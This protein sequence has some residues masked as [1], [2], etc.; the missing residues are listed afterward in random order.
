MRLAAISDVHS[1]L[2]ALREVAR[3]IAVEDVDVVVCAGDIVGYCAFPNECCEIVRNL[4]DYAVLG[5]HDVAAATQVTTS[6]NQY[7]AK[8]AVW[9]AQNMN[10]DSRSFIQS[11]KTELKFDVDDITVA[12]FHGS[13]RSLDEY[14]FEE[15]VDA[16]LIDSEGVDVMIL[17]HTHVPFVKSFGS[18]MVVNPGAVGQPRDS[19]KRASFAIID[20]SIMKGTIKRVDYDIESAA[21]AIKT[22]GLPEMLADRLFLGR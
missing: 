17:G 6:M 15:D 20:S 3:A 10:D 1:N 13:P 22:A 21:K 5:N 7:A 14:V 9:T 4:A 11:L 12:M 19:D 18:R 2:H 16:S 8:A